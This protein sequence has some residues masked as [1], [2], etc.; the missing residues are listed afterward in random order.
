MWRTVSS[1][2]LS[3][4]VVVAFGLAGCSSKAPNSRPNPAAEQSPSGHDDHAEH[5]HGEHADQAN[6]SQSAMEKMKAELVKLSPDDAVSAE[7]QHVCPVSGKMLGT[8]GA[9]KKIDVAGQQVWICCDGCKD[10]LL[11]EPDE[12]LAKL[13]KE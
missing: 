4:A 6:G 13:K 11:A 9:P 2:R 1:I 5:S 10:K 8:M 3:W 7:R 12:Y